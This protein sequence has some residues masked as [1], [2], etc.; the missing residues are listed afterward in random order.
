MHRLTTCIARNS[1]LL[2]HSNISNVNKLKQEVPVIQ[3]LDESQKP[4]IQMEGF[5]D[6]FFQWSGNQNTS[7]FAGFKNTVWRF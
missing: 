4:E 5:C 7:E 2:P 6:F 3:A 1:E